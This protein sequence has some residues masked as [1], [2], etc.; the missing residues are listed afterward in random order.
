MIGFIFS[1][2]CL[3]LLVGVVS[4]SL[5]SSSS[6]SSARFL[7]FL[8]LLLFAWPTLTTILTI[9][10]DQLLRQSIVSAFLSNC[11]IHRSRLCLCSLRSASTSLSTRVS[12]LTYLSSSRLLQTSILQVP[13]SFI[14]Q[15][16]ADFPDS[17]LGFSSNL[18]FKT[19]TSTSSFPL[20]CYQYQKN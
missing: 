16:L 10:S 19:S 11:L 12:S 9:T 2:L 6:L 17:A 4:L 15:D 3:L 20:D 8:S 18:F 5:T 1:H 14:S 13:S 7:S